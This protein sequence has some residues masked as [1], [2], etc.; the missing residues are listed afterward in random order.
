[1]GPLKRNAGGG[2]DPAV[3]ASRWRR[4]RCCIS[5]RASGIREK[6]LPRWA[7]SC[8]WRADGVP[9]WEN[10]DL[11]AE[12]DRDYGY[13]VADALA[14]MEALARR[15]QVS[16]ENVMPAYEDAFYYLWRERRLPVNVDAAQ[17]Q[18]GER[19]GARRAG[20]RV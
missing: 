15:L 10:A 18:A 20:A 8:H 4:A 9:V 7:L 12:E 17:S 5:G 14:F 6:L 2:A 3:A 1:M 11:I 13:G 16:A 19:A